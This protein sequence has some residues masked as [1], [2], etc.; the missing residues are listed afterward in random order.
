M[1]AQRREFVVPAKG[2]GPDLIENKRVSGAD[3]LI[4]LIYIGT[5]LGLTMLF[6]F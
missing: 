5:W 3:Y 2:G 1:K 4:M 6:L